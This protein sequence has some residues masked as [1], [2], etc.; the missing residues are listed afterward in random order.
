MNGIG[1][2]TIEEAKANMTMNEFQQWCV[3]RNTYGPIDGTSKLC[4][5]IKHLTFVTIKIAGDKKIGIEDL[6]LFKQKDESEKEIASTEDIVNFF[7]NL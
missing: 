3:Y 7:K 5:Y 2:N 4:E 1:G 6:E